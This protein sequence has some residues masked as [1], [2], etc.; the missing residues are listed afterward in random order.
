MRQR[1]INWLMPALLV[2]ALIWGGAVHAASERAEAEEFLKITGFD[3]ALESIKLSAGSAPA[4]IG[5]QTDDFGL[6]WTQLVDQVFDVENMQSI[7]LDILEKTL[8]PEVL[9]HANGFY[10]SAL[11]QRIV[12]A[13][14]AS[15][16]IE[17]DS[18]K[19]EAGEAIVAGLVRLG[20]RRL[21]E[22]KRM[23][24]AVGSAEASVKAMQEVQLRFL[25]AAAGADIIDLRLDADGLRA[26]MAR[27]VP[28]LL[29]S[30]QASSL[31][32][33]AYT[34]QALS[35]AEVTAYSDA[36]EHPLMRQAYELMNAV[37]YEVMANRFEALADAMR[38]LGPSTDL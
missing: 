25:M 11:G 3:V 28:E 2:W 30:V 22:L 21:E 24:A 26:M 1:L 38:N 7:A 19:K 29:Q 33:A 8:E 31:V 20:S 4:M 13:E 32:G 34:Y 23:N 17:D 6:R 10:G 37:Q 9:E 18:A 15:H 36:L 16:M 14:N 12:A 5:L 35:D 27:Q